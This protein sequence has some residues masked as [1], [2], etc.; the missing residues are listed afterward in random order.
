MAVHVRTK[1]AVLNSVK[2]LMP[3]FWGAPPPP[4]H[5]GVCGVSSYATGTIT[6]QTVQKEPIRQTIDS[7]HKQT[8]RDSALTTSRTALAMKLNTANVTIKYAYTRFISGLHKY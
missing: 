8:R 3:Q 4:Q 7:K 2:K 5:Y 1:I 6:I